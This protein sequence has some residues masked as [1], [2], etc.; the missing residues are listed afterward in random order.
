MID[1]DELPEQAAVDEDKEGP[2]GQCSPLSVDLVDIKYCAINK[3]HFHHFSREK[4]LI[5]PCP[6]GPGKYWR[7][8]RSC[9]G[10]EGF[11]ICFSLV[12]WYLGVPVMGVRGDFLQGGNLRIY[13]IIYQK[14]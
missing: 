3:I 4:S 11:A 13:L 12:P 14:N 1:S 2:E 8:M 7:K 9:W 5:T 10:R 6:W